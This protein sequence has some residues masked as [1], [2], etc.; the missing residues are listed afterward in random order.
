MRYVLLIDSAGNLVLAD[1]D[2]GARVPVGQALGPAQKAR[3]TTAVWSPAGQWTAWS[4][5]ADSPG[6]VHELRVHDE[7]TDTTRVLAEALT[8]FYLCPSPCGR[9]LSHLSAGPLGL[10]LAVSEIRSGDLRIVER[11]QPLFWAW[12]P[13]STHIAVHVENRVLISPIDG[14]ASVILSDDS[15]SF[16]A[17]WWMSAGSV[18]FV[19]E[20]RIVCAGQDGALTTLFDQ[21]DSGRFAVDPDGRRIAA[22]ARTDNGQ[23][24]TV[25]DLLTSEK[26]TVTS[27]QTA[28]FYWSP[29]GRFLAALVQASSSELQWLVFDGRGVSRLSP[30]RPGPSWMRSVLPFFEQYAH[31]H[32]VWSSDNTQLVVLSLDNDGRAEALIQGAEA[33]FTVERLPDAHLA[34]WANE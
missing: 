19:V 5:D 4:V 15:G 27:E 9:Y 12:S 26:V 10:E 24:L 7:D 29:S 20:D 21:L 11:G 25:L 8:A 18:A 13:D 16:T 33:P 17:P 32:P 30:F 6:G 31:S 3:T 14:G 34:W 1:I 2:S 22:V 23:R 28:G